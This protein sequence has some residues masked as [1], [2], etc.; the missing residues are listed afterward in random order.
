MITE[1]YFKRHAQSV[2]SLEHEKTRVL[3]EEGWKDAEKL[4]KF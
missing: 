3:S 2:F 4:P 1:I